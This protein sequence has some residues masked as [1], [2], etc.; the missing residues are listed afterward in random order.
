MKKLK[1]VGILM[2]GF[3]T[4]SIV[5]GTEMQASN[6]MVEKILFNSGVAENV[7]HRGEVWIKVNRSI[8]DINPGCPASNWYN[9][10]GY[11]VAA[12]TSDEFGK[13]SVAGLLA[14]KAAGQTISVAVDN[15][16]KNVSGICALGWY[17]VS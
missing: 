12:F 9:Q 17:E 6:L 11:L 7:G 2:I 15:S 16:R 5:S 3:T 8:A 1:S 14:A 10:N 13:Q 4:T